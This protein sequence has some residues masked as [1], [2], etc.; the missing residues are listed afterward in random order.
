[1]MVNKHGTFYIRNGWPTKILNAIQEDRYIFSPSNELNA[2]DSIGMGRVMIRA[3][4]YWAKA[5]GLVIELKDAQG[6]YCQETPLFN[7]ILEHDIYLQD[8]GSLW[9]LHRELATN[10]EEATAWYWAFNEFDHIKFTKDEFVD[11]FFMYLVKA[12][13]VYKKSAIEKEFDCFKNTY[14]SNGLF[15]IKKIIEEDTVPFFAPLKLIKHV[16]NGVYEKQRI[17]PRSIP[18]DVF[19]YFIIKDNINHLNDNRQLGIESLLVEPCQVCKY[20][21]MSYSVL[22]EMLQ[23]LEN[24]GRLR[25]YNNFGNRYIEINNID[26]QQVLAEYFHKLGR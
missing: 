17:L 18:T 22:I 20:T 3:L 14:M 19:L 2:V 26:Y 1:M 23:S 9:L 13:S 8:I 25:L 16:D 10:H 12:G 15:D 6:I 11:S 4:R 7:Q 21:N 24:Q 5:M